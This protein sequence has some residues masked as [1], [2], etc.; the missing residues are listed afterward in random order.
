MNT[1][2]QIPRGEFFQKKATVHMKFS[3]DSPVELPLHKTKKL[4]ETAKRKENRI[5]L[6]L[7]IFYFVLKMYFWTNKEQLWQACWLPFRHFPETFFSKSDNESEQKN[8]ATIKSRLRTLVKTCGMV[9]WQTC[10]KGI[11]K[12]QEFPLVV[13]NSKKMALFESVVCLM[14]VVRRHRSYIREMEWNY[15]AE[16]PKLFLYLFLGSTSSS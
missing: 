8:S 9:F 1:Y 10:R 5:S 16:C 13:T 15:F 7:I 14:K 3:F 11:A 6:S 12:L 4:V 2:K